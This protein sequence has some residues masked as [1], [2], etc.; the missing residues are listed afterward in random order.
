MANVAK[1]ILVLWRSEGLSL[2]K[3][4][5]KNGNF[6]EYPIVDAESLKRLQPFQIT[7]SLNRMFKTD[8]RNAANADKGI[9]ARMKTLYSNPRLS[10]ADRMRLGKAFFTRTESPKVVCDELEAKLGID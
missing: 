9:E 1:Q 2:G 5:D 3:D 8:M 10:E 7:D 6:F 4:T